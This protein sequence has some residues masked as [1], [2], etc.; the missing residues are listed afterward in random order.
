MGLIAFKRKMKYLTPEQVYKQFSYHSKTIAEW[1]D[2]EKIAKEQNIY[3]PNSS[4]C[5]LIEGSAV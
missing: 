3:E 2:K 1:A 5:D 4:Q